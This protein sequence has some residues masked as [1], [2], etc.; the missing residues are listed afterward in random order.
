MSSIWNRNL[1]LSIFGESHGDGIG[2]VIDGFEAG[3]KLD[4]ELIMHEMARRKPGNIL[5]TPRS[6]DDFPNIISGILDGITTGAPICAIIENKNIRSSDYNKFIP[7]P[8]HADYTAFVKY[9]GFNDI[10]GGGHFSARITA[11]LTFA[12]TL[13]KQKLAQMGILIA[14]H[15]L[16]VGHEKDRCFC[17]CDF[18]KDVFYSL[19]QSELP[20][21]NLYKENIFTQ[22]IK[23]ARDERTSIGGVIELA[24]IGVPA[25]IGEPFFDSMESILSH[26]FFSIPAVKSVEFGAG[27]SLSKMFGHEANDSPFIDKNGNISF[28]TNHNGGINGG[29]SNGMPIISKIGFKPTPSIARMQ[30]TVNLETFQNIQTEITGRH[31]PAVIVRAVPV[32]EAAMAIGIL[33]LYYENLKHEK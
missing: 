21:L 29:I 33:D 3:I 15:I 8:S 13:A 24:A 28:K 20:V 31:D 18:N 4:F 11:G 17:D 25:G 12:G 10:R 2:I 16:S 26:L 1:K 14:G 30:D 19:N 23:N 27:F 32:A 7:R 5:S 6:E 22:I 9:N